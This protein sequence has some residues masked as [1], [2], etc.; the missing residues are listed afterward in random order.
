[1]D[2]DF[3]QARASDFDGIQRIFTYYVSNTVMALV[4]DVPSTLGRLQQSMDFPGDDDDTPVYPLYL[5]VPVLVAR[6]ITHDGNKPK[7]VGYTFLGP[8]RRHTAGHPASMELYL[9]VHPDYVRQGIGGALLSTLLT[10]VRSEP[11][12]RCYDWVVAEQYN[13]LFYSVKEYK[14]SRIVAA[15]SVD[16]ASEDGGEW[17]PGWLETKGFVEYNRLKGATMKFNKAYVIAPSPPLLCPNC[18]QCS[19]QCFL[20]LTLPISSTLWTRPTATV[21]SSPILT[22][23]TTRLKMPKATTWTKMKKKKTIRT[24]SSQFRSTSGPQLA[25]EYMEGNRGNRHWKSR[26]I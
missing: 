25:T 12:V 16:P 4:R 8:T 19:Y 11:G 7:I 20:G 21:T 9:F 15:V 18:G 13:L 24:V 2:F 26:F 10:L 14:A 23:V 6:R 17:L 1:M 22:T 3:R 5:P